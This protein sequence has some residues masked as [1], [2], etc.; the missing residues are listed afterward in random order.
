MTKREL[1]ER[2][3]AL[4]VPDAASVLV[5]ASME[6]VEINYLDCD[7]VEVDDRHVPFVYIVTD[8][9]V[10]ADHQDAI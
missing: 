7:V 1:V 8:A 4:D 5:G 10:V 9:A 2:L 3:E 6:M